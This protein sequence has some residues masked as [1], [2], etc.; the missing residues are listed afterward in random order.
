MK[1]YALSCLGAAL[2]LAIAGCGGGSGG[3]HIYTLSATQS[4]LRK[5]GF[6]ASVVTDFS[7]PGTGGN[8][9]VRLTDVGQ[10]LLAPNTPPG[11]PSPDEFVF[12]VFDKTAAAALATEKRAMTL[13]FQS[14]RADG[15]QMTRAQL[16]AGVGL[17]DNVFYYSAVGVL[18]KSE[19]T[20]IMSC[21][22]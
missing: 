14:L 9:R 11:A 12:L 13:A 20:K 5:N 8:L 21:L 1:R 2:A 17:T 3:A 6:Q 4:C 15:L 19:R 18:A 16:R 10:A 22:R 7:L